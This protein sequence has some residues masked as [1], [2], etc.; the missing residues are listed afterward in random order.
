MLLPGTG[1]Y[2]IQPVFVEDLAELA[3]VSSRGDHNIEIDAVGPE[4]FTY[5][6]MVK[7]VRDKIGSSCLVMPSPKWLTYAAGR[8]LGVFL[9]DI[10]LT[11][12]EV[13]GLSAGLLVS[14]SGAEPPTSTRLSEWLDRH[15]PELG[16]RYAS[17]VQRH[18]R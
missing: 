8:L 1:N 15:G 12:D 14:K 7:M 9:K 16:R 4:V 13:K 17:E 11:W 5:V 18:Y 6:E 10:V 2:R 3:V